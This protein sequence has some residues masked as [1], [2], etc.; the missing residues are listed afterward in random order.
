MR[1]IKTIRDAAMGKDEITRQDLADVKD[2]RVDCLIDTERQTYFD[3]ESNAWKPIE[4][5]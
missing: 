5:I 2:G 3:A 4:R 1:Y